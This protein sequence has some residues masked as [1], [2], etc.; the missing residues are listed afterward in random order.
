VENAGT[1]GDR[2]TRDGN[3]IAPRWHY[4]PFTSIQPSSWEAKA[5][6]KIRP[7]HRR[8]RHSRTFVQYPFLFAYYSRLQSIRLRG[9]RR[10]ERKEEAQHPFRPRPA[11]RSLLYDVKVLHRN[12]V[13]TPIEYPPKERTIGSGID[14]RYSQPP[15]IPSFPSPR[16]RQTPPDIPVSAFASL[17]RHRL[18]TISLHPAAR[19]IQQTK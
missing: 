13:D 18:G 6:G 9:D 14:D 5:V 1:L 17:R 7:R 3:H 16:H 11:N 12:A 4:H 19:T 10:G 8:P 2:P 15:F